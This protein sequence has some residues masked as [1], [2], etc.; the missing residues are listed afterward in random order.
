MPLLWTYK[1]STAWA[2]SAAQAKLF[3]LTRTFLH[4]LDNQLRA[5]RT[6]ENFI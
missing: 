2:A 3:N 6:K 1:L 4:F 5:T